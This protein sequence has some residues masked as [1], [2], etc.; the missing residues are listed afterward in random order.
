MNSTVG[1]STT[2]GKGR[3]PSPPTER[4][5]AV[6]EL[7]AGRENPLGAAEIADELRLSRST[8]LAVL[9]SLAERGWV[10]RG[11]D[12]R[13]RLGARLI[14]LTARGAS[15]PAVPPGAE[16][17]LRELAEAA[18]CGVALSAVTATELTFV[19]VFAGEGRIPAGITRDTVVPLRAPAGASA[20][21]FRSEQEQA[22]W[23]AGADEAHRDRLA[24]ALR[25]LRSE[26]VAA[27]GIGAAAPAQLDVLADVVEHLA[28]HPAP[29]ELRSRVRSLMTDI[30]GLPYA[31]A[32]VASE[33]PLPL[34]YLV[35]PIF[36]ATGAPA[37]ELQLGPLRASA[38]RDERNHYITH[39]RT[40]AQN[41]SQ[42]EQSPQIHRRR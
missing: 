41:L 18:G 6:V 36:D 3:S 20:V 16:E 10:S 15:E 9:T 19:A 32:D 24:E 37:W 33:D 4:V 38:D 1:S 8:A 28:E 35:A 11:T 40:T 14:G 26:F 29:R 7:L 27:W 21:A 2:D 13:Y 23:L 34:S 17:A 12:L 22:R 39:L 30:S 5:V 25:L 42:P 31:E